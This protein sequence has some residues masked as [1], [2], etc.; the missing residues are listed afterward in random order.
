M[1]NVG[2]LQEAKVKTLRRVRI[3]NRALIMC[4]SEGWGDDDV[5]RV[6]RLLPEGAKA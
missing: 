6:R 1:N 5:V 3:A 4:V 2:K